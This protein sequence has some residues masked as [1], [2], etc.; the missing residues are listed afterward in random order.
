VWYMRMYD[1]I[2][3]KKNR[4]ELSKEEMSYWVN[5][6]TKGLIPDYQVAALLMA[7]F[8]Q[9]LSIKETSYLTE[10]M[11][12]SGETIDLSNLPGIKGDKHS[13]GGV[14][15][16]TTL[17]LAP[18]LA[19]LGI[20]M[21]KMSGR[22]L[23]HTGGTLDKLE[24]IPGFRVDLTKEEYINN[25]NKIGLAVIGQTKT[26]VP[27][28]KQIYALRDVTATVE[29]IPLIAA[30]VM[31]KKLAAGGDII[32]LDV[33]YGSGAFMKTQEQAESLARIMVGIGRNMG[34]KA[35][36][37]ITGM[38]CPLGNAVGNALEVKEAINVLKGKGPADVR[39]LCLNLA[40]ITLY[41]GGKV[42]SIEKGQELAELHL[43]DG[44][45]LHK[46]RDFIAAQ[47]GNPQIINDE[48][49][50]PEAKFR[51][52]L[53]SDQDGYIDKMDTESIGIAG[54]KLG[55]GRERKE[56][57]ID[58]G[59]GIVFYKKTGDWVNK[60]ETIGMIHANDENRADEGMEMLKRSIIFHEKKR[61]PVPLI[62]RL[63]LD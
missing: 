46:F 14:G 17:V 7:V 58:P 34:K 18:L 48:K 33:K 3:K 30:S 27:A 26:I 39:E 23:G 10:A 52:S 36:G 42:P 25:L 40:G 54:M 2:N 51:F 20:T 4:G 24:S 43:D 31:S 56:D 49:L 62:H 57:I 29:S 12:N 37:V 6:F 47:E 21:A 45:A 41:L 35:A 60:G 28:D 16:K 50:L 13:T 55:A 1:I 5:G 15:D 44:S 53:L 59:V 32:V 9:G 61:D 63:V 8:F 22:G 38:D 11:I 19:S